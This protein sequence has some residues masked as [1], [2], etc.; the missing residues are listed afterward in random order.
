MSLLKITQPIV[1]GISNLPWLRR[2]LG[3][4]ISIVA[5][6]YL[7]RSVRVLYDAVWIR[8]DGNVAVPLQHDI[9]SWLSSIPRWKPNAAERV[10][11]VGEWWF[12]HYTPKPNDIIIDVGAGMGEDSLLFSQLVGEQG[13]VYSFEAHP[14]TF[15]CLNKALTY[16]HSQN[17]KPIHAAVSAESGTL[18]I[19]DLPSDRWEENSVMTTR[20]ASGQKLISVRA[21][22][23]DD[24]ELIQQHDSIQFLKMNIE[25][26]EI[27]ALQGMS[28][29]LAKVEHA[30]IACHD[31]LGENSPAMRTKKACVQILLD[32]GFQVFETPP[33][34]PPWQRDHLHAI[35]VQ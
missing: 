33:D 29:T 31:F 26:A 30:C 7:K 16:S 35:R 5:S 2:P 27:N 12:L 17:V 15:L 3:S 32:A 11:V 25:G 24:F 6:T 10:N 21:I 8:Q 18:Q 28:K 19:E 9:W 22:A 20:E 23:I 1:S 13:K 4:F 34:S 14:H